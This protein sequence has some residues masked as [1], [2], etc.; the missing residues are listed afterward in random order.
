MGP[1]LHYNITNHTALSHLQISPHY[2]SLHNCHLTRSSNTTPHSIGHDQHITLM[3]TKHSICSNWVRWYV[4]QW[5]AS[6]LTY[7]GISF[8][9]P[10]QKMGIASYL[11]AFSTCTLTASRLI[12]TSQAQHPTIP[13]HSPTH[14]HL[15]HNHSPA[16]NLRS[17][18]KTSDDKVICPP[19]HPTS[20][21]SDFREKA[22]NK[23]RQRSP[24]LPAVSLNSFTLPHNIH[25]LDV[26]Y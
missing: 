11:T 6:F 9:H 17:T 10:L 14:Q 3:S 8:R 2:T 13:I 12:T 16:N 24:R 20:K 5:H 1:M 23:K 26:E 21:Q 15:Q 4:L 22:V 25:T 19:L 7:A 18:P